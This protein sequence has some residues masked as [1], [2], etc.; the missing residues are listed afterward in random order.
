MGINSG[1]KSFHLNFGIED[2]QLWVHLSD[3]DD[4]NAE[5]EGDGREK[6]P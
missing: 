6:K 4:E 1:G 5:W 3:Q 2:G